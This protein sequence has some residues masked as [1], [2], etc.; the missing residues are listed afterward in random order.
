MNVALDVK[1]KVRQVYDWYLNE[2]SLIRQACYEL[3]G[4][5]AYV[6]GLGINPDEWLVSSIPPT[7]VFDYA[8]PFGDVVVWVNGRGYF[9]SQ[10]RSGVI[11]FSVN[12][13]G[14]ILPE[15]P[16][17]DTDEEEGWEETPDPIGVRETVSGYQGFYGNYSRYHI[18]E[19]SRNEVSI[20]E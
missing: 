7:V 8:C 5:W 15:E 20:L 14:Q 3:W 9:L 12:T 6:T 16:G 13:I 4:P 19:P 1:T 10:I 2:M 11:L 18:C 17:W